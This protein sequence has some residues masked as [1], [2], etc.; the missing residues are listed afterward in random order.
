MSTLSAAIRRARRQMDRDETPVRRALA[1]AYREAIDNLSADLDAVTAMIAEARAAGIDV[2]P[3]WLRRQGRYRTLMAQAEF[4]FNRFASAGER[5]LRDGQ[6]RA[7]SGGAASAVELMEAAGINVTMGAAVNVPAVERLV[8]ALQ[9]GSP[10]REVLDRYGQAAASV[11]ERELTAGII[12][13][14]G[15]R[16]VVRSIR[17]GIGS[18]T[19]RAR[20]EAL[21]RSESMRAFR[22]GLAD[23]FS[24]FEHVAIGYRRVAA[25][26]SRTCLA[27]LA[28]DGQISKT[29]PRRFHVNCR[30]IFH[31]VGKNSTVVYETGEEWFARQDEATQRSMFPSQ[32]SFNAFR[33]GDITLRDFVGNKRSSVWGPS[34]YQLSGREAVARRSRR[35]AG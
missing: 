25:K 19:N 35:H 26:G 1:R 11:I 33:N 22:G 2:S 3:D 13:G 7:V 8:F 27:C 16:E 17:R 31:L 32:E 15:P 23:Q 18:G 24:Q 12:E 20:L 30:C 34:V 21:V 10:V 29:P 9:P 6:A 5:I 4:E 14:K 28:L